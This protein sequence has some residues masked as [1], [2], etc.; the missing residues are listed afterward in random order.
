M[1]KIVYCFALL[2]MVLVIGL[3]IRSYIKKDEPEFRIVS[4]M[5]TTFDNY[6]VVNIS[7]IVNVKKYDKEEMLVKVRDY[8]SDLNGEPDEITISL[9]NSKRDFEKFNLYARK[10]FIKE[11]SQD[12]EK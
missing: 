8:Y 9:F 12:S 1:K 6:K 10:K 11:A 5:K 2:V 4:T 7:V 3:G